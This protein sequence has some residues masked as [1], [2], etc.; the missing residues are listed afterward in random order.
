MGL[1]L[2]QLALPGTYGP[3]EGLVLQSD[4]EYCPHGKYCG[5]AGLSSP[6]SDCTAG[7]YCTRGATSA[8]QNDCPAGYYCPAGTYTPIHCP[9]GTYNTLPRKTVLSDCVA[10]DAGSFCPDIAT[11][12]A[13]IPGTNDCATGYE[14]IGGAR[15]ATPNDKITGKLCDLGNNCAICLSGSYNA[16]FSIPAC[17][18]CPPG[19]YCDNSI[20]STSYYICPAGNYCPEGDKTVD[21]VNKYQCPAGTYSAKTGLH[22][23]S[24]CTP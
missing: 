11:T 21:F 22:D 13:P 20:S 4:C 9:P 16:K 17:V 12:A 23:S 1:R 18:N 15:T 3:R 10:C 5:T 6:G 8:T 14:C 19:Y 24:Q 7:Y 2:Q